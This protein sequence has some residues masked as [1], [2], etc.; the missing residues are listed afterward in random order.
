MTNGLEHLAQALE[1]Y[2]DS[3]VIIGGTA[4]SLVLDEQKLRFRET[5]DLDMVVRYE[6]RLREFSR[7]LWKYIGEG[8]Y[9][10]MEQSS[11]RPHF[12]RFA[13][14]A[15]PGYPKMIELFSPHPDYPIRPDSAIAPLHI[16]DDISSLSAIVLD[17]DYYRLI[18]Q[19]RETVDGLSVLKPEYL[20]PLKAK[21]WLDLT[22]RKTM[23]LAGDGPHV[24]GKNITKH[25]NDI[26]RLAPAIED[27][28][29]IDIGERPREDMRRFIEA[30]RGVDMPLKQL[31]VDMSQGQV[32]ELFS[33]IYL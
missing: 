12:Y 22:E 28:T 13:K 31:G 1:G 9:A 4:C 7:I 11:G 8:H 18:Q 3:Y 10:S 21:A 27:D 23:E 30:M 16:S 19:R 17:E 32:L 29:R 14:P 15:T 5:K 6:Q 33:A 26:F 24:D 20:V 2:G 25:R